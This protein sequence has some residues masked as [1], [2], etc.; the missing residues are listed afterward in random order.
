MRSNT[1]IYGTKSLAAVFSG[2][3]GAKSLMMRVMLVMMMV[4]GGKVAWGAEQTITLTY[5]SFGLTTSYATKTATV[6]GYSFTVNQG[7]KG[8][9]NVIQ[10]NSSK[11]EGVL[12]NTTAIPGLKSI[13]VNVSS[14]NKTYTIY[15]GNTQKPTGTS[16]GTGTT[17]S[18]INITGGCQYFALKVSGAS[19]FS[20]IVITYDPTPHTVTFVATGSCDDTSLTEPSAGSGVVLPIANPPTDCATEYTFYGW[21]TADDVTETSAVPE[22][23]GTNGETYKPS[24]DVTLYAIYKKIK[25][26]PIEKTYNFSAIPDFAS[27]GTTYKEHIVDYD[28]ATAT[29]ESANHQTATITDIPVTK[30]NYV[31]FVLKDKDSRIKEVTFVCRQWTNKA[32]T[33]TLHY[34]INGGTLYSSTGTTSTNFTITKNNLNANTNAVKITF[35]STNQVGISS[36]RIKVTDV[37][38][39]S[40]PIC[41]S[42]T[43]TY[44]ANRAT[45]GSVPEDNTA[46]PIGTTVTVL[47]NTGDLAKYGYSF[48]GWN[49]AD[50]GSG[51]SYSADDTFIITENTTLYAQ[52]TQDEHTI[53]FNTNGVEDNADSPYYYDDIITDQ[54]L[55]TYEDVDKYCEGKHFVGWSESK[56]EDTTDEWPTMT[57]NGQIARDVVSGDKI[58]YAVYANIEENIA[59]L[60]T[61]LWSETWSGGSAN[62]T[63]SEYGKE[64]TIVYEGNVTYNQVVANTKLYDANIAGG[65]SPELLLS[66]NKTWTISGI[67]TGGAYKML[68]T[69]KSN[70]TTF[71][72]TTTAPISDIDIS[73]SETN[74]IITASE[75]VTTFDLILENTGSNARIDDVELK[76]IQIYGTGYTTFCPCNYDIDNISDGDLVWAGK[77]TG[78]VWN[79]A[80]N[81]VVYNEGEGYRPAAN[82]P[83]ASGNNVFLLY[84]EECFINTSSTLTSDITCNNLTITGNIGISLGEHNLT[85]K[86]N[87]T[88]NGNAISGN[89]KI[90]FAGISEQT[91]SGTTTTFNNVE[92]NNSNGIT[93]STEPTINGT[94]T[95]TSGIINGNVVFGEDATVSGASTSSHVDGIV[96]KS[97]AANGFT[98][99]TGSNGNLGK[100]V[101]T[102]GSA[103]NVSVQYFS[104]PDGFGTNDLPRWW[105]AADMSGENPFNHVSNVEYWRISSTE[106]I[107][108]NFVAEAST[109]MHFNSETA[110][111]D[112]IPTNIQ[113]AFYDNNRWT[114]VG[115]SASIDG[116]TLT[117]NGAEIPASATRGISGNYTTFGS[118]SKS[119]ILPIELTSFSANCD[120]RS[121]LIEWTTATE[122]NNDFF[123]LE[124]S[125]DAINFKEIA[126]VAGAGNSIEPINYAYTD[127]GA[128]SGDNYYRLVQ[129]DYDGTSTASEIIV[130]NCPAEVLGEPDV[131]IFPNPFHS[132]ITIHAENLGGTAASIEIYDMLGRIVMTKQVKDMH[133]SSE[134]VLQL[135]NLPAG[136][137]N[138]RV[139]MRN[140]LLN[141]QIV[142]Q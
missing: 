95:F 5:N 93:V 91:I 105:N 106:A 97:G 31:S 60:N 115:G 96:T 98:F 127:Y 125:N 135:G 42:A 17:T 26:T 59:P 121:S 92:F 88:N 139:C 23:V 29:F 2:F 58:Y 71:T 8:S 117:I 37:I 85:V 112:K 7:Y 120:G 111:E 114:N 33:I 51:D 104:N 28:I 133:D 108:A 101:V 110:E 116:N 128:R 79:S 78:A 141:K 107:T 74:W 14:G 129:V 86:G 34:S 36:C 99:P 82:A 70:K 72:L 138:L 46:Y 140:I 39:N 109:D 63:P 102:D 40:N 83:T 56:I 73:G 53:L 41:A 124:R 10:M 122:K 24:T 52:W 75:N 76:I 130:A 48:D 142:K 20:S 103:T 77:N 119:T 16:A 12:Y 132:E 131:H 49:T 38:Y 81:W 50:D 69:F 6:N 11:G 30:G 80:D 54:S 47:G 68:L 4:V 118:K 65:T 18:T 61:I 64:G 134:V 67:P 113:M 22:I 9:G 3:F 15:Q 35:N 32:Q 25:D 136:T 89:G 100:V 57:T 123:V 66:E 87:I 27:W 21:T 55:P 90:I 1:S 13:T 84:N 45:D 137:Y 19:Y 43:V 126:R 44:D 62:E 94:A